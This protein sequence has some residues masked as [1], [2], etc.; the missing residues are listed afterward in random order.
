MQ[1][2]S[3]KMLTKGGVGGIL[4]K[5]SALRGDAVNTTENF[6]KELRKK[7]L[8]MW[9]GCVKLKKLLMY[10]A[11]RALKKLWKKF[12]TNGMKFGIIVMFRRIRRVPCKLNNVTKRKHQTDSFRKK[13]RKRS[14][15]C[16]RVGSE[17]ILPKA[18]TIKR[19]EAMTNS[20]MK[21]WT[22]TVV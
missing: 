8:T 21:V 22:T 16:G 20:S 4:A 6:V 10:W 17:S 11:D 5:L 15:S 7:Y 13:F 2:N 12:L 3:K 18:A 19:I 9:N 14:W 1:K